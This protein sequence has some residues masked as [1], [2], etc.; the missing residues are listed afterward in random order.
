MLNNVNFSNIMMTLTLFS[1]SMVSHSYEVN[2]RSLTVDD[3]GSGTGII[4]CPS[5]NQH[6][7]PITFKATTTE[8]SVTGEW[9]I[10][11]HGPSGD[12]IK[13]GIITAGNISP[14]GDFILTGKESNDNICNGLGIVSSISIVITGVCVSDPGVLT[15]VKFTASNR[16]R[17]DFLSSPICT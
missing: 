4:S 15:T 12:L 5:G 9:D 2:A 10:S 13:S 8:S 3:P 11:T 7:G 17:A 1:L 6:E 16:E 14:S